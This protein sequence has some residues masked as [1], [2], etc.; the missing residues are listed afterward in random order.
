MQ[1]A[2]WIRNKRIS[3]LPRSEVL[4]ATADYTMKADWLRFARPARHHSASGTACTIQ[5]I[6]ISCFAMSDHL[7]PDPRPIPPV[8]PDSEDCCR[9]GCE[10]C[11]FER[12]EEALE[13]HRKAMLEWERRHP[14]E[15]P[16]KA[17]N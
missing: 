15:M 11:V 6:S 2:R 12:Y 1:A 8:R 17:G 9:G 3:P 13:R 5:S 14:R 7:D 16:T 4:S 10:P